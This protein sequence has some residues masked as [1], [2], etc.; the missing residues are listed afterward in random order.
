MAYEEV[1]DMLKSAVESGSVADK[2]K[3]EPVQPVFRKTD[4]F[5]M[6]PVLEK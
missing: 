3:G 2:L 1:L 4:N 5:N 6:K